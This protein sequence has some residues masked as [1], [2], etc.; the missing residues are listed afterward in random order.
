[1]HSAPDTCGVFIKQCEQRFTV[2]S[3][4]FA[5]VME[6]TVGFAGKIQTEGKLD[7]R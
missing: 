4:G 7:L 6:A 3:A 1:M 5:K 2:N